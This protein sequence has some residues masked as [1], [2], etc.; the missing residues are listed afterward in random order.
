MLD[1][2]TI[3]DVRTGYFAKIPKVSEFNHNIKIYVRPKF[4]KKNKYHYC[5]WHYNMLN[6]NKWSLLLFNDKSKDL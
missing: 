5:M 3:R 1:I 4:Y 6:N 2:A